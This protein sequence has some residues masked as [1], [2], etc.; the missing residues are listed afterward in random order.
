MGETGLRLVVGGKSLGKTKMMKKL[1][2]DAGDSPLLYINMRLPPKAKSTDALEC[3]QAEARRKWSMKNFPPGLEKGLALLKN[4]FQAAG[5]QSFKSRDGDDAVDGGIELVV[6]ELL[7]MPKPQEFVEAW[8]SATVAA[9]KIP[10]IIIDEANM[11]FPNGNG[12]GQNGNAKRE[13]AYQALAALVALTKEESKACVFL[14]AS[15]YTFP[16]HLQKLGFNKYDAIQT[17][18]APEVEEEPM[19]ALL[20]RWGLP[21]DIAKEL[22]ETLWCSL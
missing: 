12:N 2:A 4:I 18:V 17:I 5:K 6:A 7:N 22:S 19:L 10:T 1:V 3:L 9:D 15:D 20:M 11:A 21:E 13:A 14:V 8:V 16:F